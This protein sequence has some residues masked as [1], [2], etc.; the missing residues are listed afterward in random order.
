MASYRDRLNPEL[1]RF[2]GLWRTRILIGAGLLVNGLAGV[3]CWWFE[4][5]HQRPWEAELA[6]LAALSLWMLACWPREIICG[7]AGIRQRQWLGLRRLH[8][9]WEDV[10][11]LEEYRELGGIGHWLGLEDRALRIVS[12]HG[13][14]CHT[15]RHPDRNRF[16]LECRMR[17]QE[18]SRKTASPQQSPRRWHP[19]KEGQT[20]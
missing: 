2:P 14:I 4:T 5:G 19:Q 15:P 11:A 17:M 12:N 9:A 6:V 7:P 13:E 8:L 10:L 20:R 1:L 3:L 16:L 18:W